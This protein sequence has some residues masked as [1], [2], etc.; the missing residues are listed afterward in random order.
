[1]KITLEGD[2][3]E[4]TQEQLE[5]I[6]RIVT[7]L[8]K[9][10]APEHGELYWA[11]GLTMDS[12]IIK[13]GIFNT[14][15]TEYDIDRYR[16]ATNSVYQTKEEAEKALLRMKS[17]ERRHLPKMGEHYKTVDIDGNVN[18]IKWVGDVV[19]GGRYYQGTVW[20]KDTPDKEVRAW[21]KEYGEA[22]M[23]S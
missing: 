18:V 19:D 2:T 4:V 10:W 20:H 1:M 8:N 9:K 16:I 17:A 6:K 15:N 13:G 23:V 21:V 3:L 14:Y 12:E 5:L 11:L 7:P 22:W